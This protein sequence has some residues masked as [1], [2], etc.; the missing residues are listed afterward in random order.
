MSDVKLTDNSQ[1]FLN[2]KDKA[3]A[4]A[5]EAVGLQAEGY[6]KLELANKPHRIDTGRLRASISHTAKRETAYIGTN[7]EY[8]IYVHEG[9]WKMQPNR[10]LKNA[11]EKHIA[12]YKKIAEQYLKNAP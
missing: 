2:A 1:L 5:L 9:K 6:A 11:V 8:A 12:E 3:I 4:V 10:F 7:V